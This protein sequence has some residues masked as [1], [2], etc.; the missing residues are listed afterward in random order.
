MLP[1]I[2]R[3]NS[4]NEIKP[5]PFRSSLYCV[6]LAARRTNATQNVQWLPQSGY[7]ATGSRIGFYNGNALLEKSVE[8]V[9]VGVMAQ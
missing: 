4:L 2:G 6:N 8:L 1:A 9:F 7:L 3:K 5:S